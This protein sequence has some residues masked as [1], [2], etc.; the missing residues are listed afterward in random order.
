MRFEWDQDKAARNKEL[1]GVS[2]EE[3]RELFETNADVLEIYDVEHSTTEDRYKSLGPIRQGLVLVVWTER[4]DDVIRIISAWW[5]T[6]TEQ[7]MYRDFV[8]QLHGREKRTDG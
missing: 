6:R 3:A 1:H 7:Q 4:T 5:A 2:F 8:E